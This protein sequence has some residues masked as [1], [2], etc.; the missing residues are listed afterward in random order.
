[1]FDHNATTVW[2][3]WGGGTSLNH[4][5]LGSVGEWLWRDLAGLN[6]DPDQ[7]GYKHFVVRPLFGA[8]ITTLKASYDSVRGPIAIQWKTQGAKTT[9]DVTVPPNTTADVCVP[10]ASADDVTE[11][12]DKADK[13]T[14]VRVIRTEPGVV[15]FAVASGKYEFVGSN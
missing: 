13:A 12:G 10:A 2:E 3:N 11:G 14:G 4:Y 8:G 5:A 1:M 9:L 7:P 15:V 6:P